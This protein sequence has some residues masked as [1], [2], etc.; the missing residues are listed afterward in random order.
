MNLV[1]ETLLPQEIWEPEF[2]GDLVY[3]FRKKNIEKSNLLERLATLHIIKGQYI[4]KT[5]C[6][7]FNSVMVDNYVFLF[8]C[9][10]VSR[11]SN[12]VTVPT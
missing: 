1:L 11:I 10:A 9:T 4:T 5:A 2:S 7:V 12:S 6:L 8:N 3:K